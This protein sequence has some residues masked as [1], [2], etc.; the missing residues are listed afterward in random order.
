MRWL[1]LGLLSV[2]LLTGCAIQVSP[3]VQ[4]MPSSPTRKVAATFTPKPISR[5][6]LPASTPNPKCLLPCFYGIIPGRTTVTETASLLGVPYPSHEAL[7]WETK[8]PRRPWYTSDRYLPNQIWFDNEVVSSIA[9]HEQQDVTLQE[10]VDK[11]GEPEAITI[12]NPDIFNLADFILIYASKGIA[13]LGTFQPGEITYAQ[14]TPTP[15]IFVDSE[16]YFPPIPAINLTPRIVTQWGHGDTVEGI[17]PWRGFGHPV[18][19]TP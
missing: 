4:S 5:I 12:G 13:F 3:T 14:Y 7:T 18:V 16:V 9:V 1:V 6:T 19:G 2:V 15:D 10:I 8:A 17:Y 11:Y